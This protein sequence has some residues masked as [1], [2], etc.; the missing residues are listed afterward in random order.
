[1]TE[2]AFWRSTVRPKL[3]IFGML[4]RIE[5]AVDNGMPDTL[6]CIKGRTGLVELKHDYRWPI[7]PDT[8]FRFNHFD[9]GQVQWL[10]DWE[11]VGGRCF[12]L[13]QVERDYI[14]VPAKHARTLQQGVTRAEFLDLAVAHGHA[15]F[16]TGAIVQCLVR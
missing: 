9:I 15:R 1:M 6:Y 13:A 12:I 3:G 4:R 10:E 14:L 11:R 2:A 7:R 5:N 8:P 16:P